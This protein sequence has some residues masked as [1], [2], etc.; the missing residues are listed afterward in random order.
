MSAVIARP[1]LSAMILAGGRSRRMGTDKALLTLPSGQP[2][3]TKI[4]QVAQTLTSDVVVMTP[5][6]ERYE[7]MLPPA[8]KLLSERTHQNGPLGGFV[9]GWNYI[10]SDWCLLLACD[11]PQLE[12]QPLGEW[13]HWLQRQTIS[14]QTISEQTIAA[15]MSGDD[16]SSDELNGPGADGAIASLTYRDRLYPDSPLANSKP[17]ASKQ[18]IPKKQSMPGKRW[19]PLCGFYHRSCLPSLHRHLDAALNQDHPRRLSFQSW[20]E[21]LNVMAYDALPQSVLFNCNT[22]EDWASLQL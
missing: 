1:T 20:L 3:L 19:E 9:Q 12:S 21:P 15:Q 6:P 4:T 8:V 18:P 17:W 2:L 11:L 14:E 5:W 13:W 10:H 22:A 16:V 7:A